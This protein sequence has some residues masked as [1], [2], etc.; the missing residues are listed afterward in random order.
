MGTEIS[1]GFLTAVNTATEAL[2]KL[3]STADSHHRVMVCELMG[4]NAGWITL[5]AGVASGGVT[6]EDPPGIR[7]GPS[8]QLYLAY[9]RDP[10]GHKL[11]A[12]YR[13]PKA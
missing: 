10:D 5:T 4:R 8:G 7:Q 12:T 9:L 13:Y 6:C 2:D 3:H 11:C 1:F